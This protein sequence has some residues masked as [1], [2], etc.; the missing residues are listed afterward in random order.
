[1]KIDARIYYTSTLSAILF[2]GNGQMIDIG[3]LDAKK[4]WLQRVWERI[5]FDERGLVTDTGVFALTT[6]FSSAQ[7]GSNAL[8]PF[9]YHATGTTNTAPVVTN[10]ALA[11]ELSNG[12]G[13]PATRPA[14][15]SQTATGGAATATATFVS[16]A[17][18]PYTG[19]AAIVEWGLFNSATIAAGSLW[20]RRIFSTINVVTGDSIQFTYTLSAASGGS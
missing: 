19:T 4:P 17:T 20:D 3:D 14:A 18:I 6:E 10:T 11:A 12:A 8:A 2:R 16:V 9:Q 7:A 13:A 5:H 1:M 15:S